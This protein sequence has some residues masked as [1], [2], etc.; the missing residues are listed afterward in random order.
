[1]NRGIIS[2]QINSNKGVTLV[3]FSLTLQCGHFIVNGVEKASKSSSVIGISHC[4]QGTDV[5]MVSASH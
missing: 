2:A 1:M 4:G 3:S 5:F